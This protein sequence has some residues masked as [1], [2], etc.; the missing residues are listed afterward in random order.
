MI[1]DELVLQDFGSFAGRQALDLT[2][3]DDRPVIVIAALNGSGKTTVLEA[4]QLALYGPLAPTSVRRGAAHEAYLSRMIH[5]GADR[6]AGAGVELAFRA[7]VAGVQRAFRIR[8]SWWTTPGGRLKEELRV[9]VD[10]HHDPAIT[11]A[12]AEHVEQLVPRGVAGLFFF[13]GEQIEA[14]ADLETSRDLVE[15]AVSGLLGLDLI[16]R[17]V[18]D[19]DVLERRKRTAAVADDDQPRIDS[20]AR[21]VESLRAEEGEARHQFDEATGQLVSARVALER[22][23]DRLAREGGAAHDERASREAAAAVTAADLAAA[24]HRLLEANSGLTPLLLVAGLLDEVAR[25]SRAEQTQAED[26]ALAR[27][28]SQRDQQLLAQIATLVADQHADETARATIVDWLRHD[29]TTRSR[30][31]I[32][33]VLGCEAS[34]AIEAESLAGGGLNDLRLQVAELLTDVEAAREAWEQAQRALAAVP[35]ADALA[36]LLAQRDQARDTVAVTTVAVGEREVALT[37]AR[38]GRERAETRRA[39][40]LTEVTRDRLQAE[41]AARLLDHAVRARGTLRR[42]REAATARHVQRIQACVLEAAHALLR[43]PD[44]IT[45]V[46]IDP[47]THALTLLGSDGQPLRPAGLS[48]GERQLLAVSLLWGLAR[49][50]GRPLPVV[51]DTPL[52]RLDGPHRRRLLDR[53]LPAAS[54]QVVVLSTDTEVDLRALDRLQASLSHVVHLAHDPVRHATDVR[55]GYLDIREE[56]LA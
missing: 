41:D 43:K 1:L 3:R 6:A 9:L 37:R 44:L 17:L 8:R 52:G 22:V 30:R 26:Q 29:R 18:G 28:L 40:A 5:R 34:V 49:A 10:G 14:L 39:A 23:E 38:A 46:R 50:A 53:Y 31:H 55:E 56:S 42:L 2:P 15:T 19:L 21:W 48:A 24:E 11:R 33:V 32:P 51:I 16:D 45:D 27:R 7:H 54:H 12:W 13:D 25:Q 36:E 4:L 47:S 20:L 35:S